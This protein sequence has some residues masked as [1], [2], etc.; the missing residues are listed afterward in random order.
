[1]RDPSAIV[2]HMSPRFDATFRAITSATDDLRVDDLVDR[3]P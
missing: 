3:D 2:A 1:M